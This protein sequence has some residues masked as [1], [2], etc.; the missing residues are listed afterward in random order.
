[1]FP[2]VIPVHQVTIREYRFRKITHNDKTQ[3][4][5]LTPWYKIA[6]RLLSSDEHK[7]KSREN[8]IRIIKKLGY[9]RYNPARKG[10]RYDNIDNKHID[11]FALDFTVRKNK[12]Y[13][14]H[15]L[16]SFYFWPIKDGRG[17]IRVDIAIVYDR[18]QLKSVSH[19]YRGREDEIKRDGFVFKN[20]NNKPAAILGIIKI[21]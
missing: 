12:S 15:A 17:P 20:P 8:M 9:D 11:L 16:E 13:I 19:R 18:V 10:D 2:M 14:A 21:L 1:M 4:F 3:S 7:G 5:D 6:V